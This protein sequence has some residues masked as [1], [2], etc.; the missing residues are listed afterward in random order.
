MQ[1]KWFR[2]GGGVF[3]HT[4]NVFSP[5]RKKKTKQN[6]EGVR[7]DVWLCFGLNAAF[8][9]QAEIAEQTQIKSNT[10]KLNMVLGSSKQRRS[11][12]VLPNKQCAL[13]YFFLLSAWWFK[14][15]LKWHFVKKCLNSWD[16]QKRPKKQK[17]LGPWCQF[18]VHFTHHFQFLLKMFLFYLSLL[19]EL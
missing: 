7:E 10:H 6:M 16:S 1:H 4:G 2:G 14:T 11:N 13:L 18:N 15:D 12:G 3:M 8:F 17:P 5:G 9:D 19:L